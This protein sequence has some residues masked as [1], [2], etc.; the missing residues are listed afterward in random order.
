MVRYVT[1]VVDQRV[2]STGPEWDGFAAISFASS[3]DPRERLFGSPAGERIVRD[4]IA[5]FIGHT[6]A[7][8]VGEYVQKI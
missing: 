2:S 4:D 5:R 3:S 7:Y 6:F 1:N 8:F